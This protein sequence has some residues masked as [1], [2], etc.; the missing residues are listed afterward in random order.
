MNKFDG[1]GDTICIRQE[2]QCL[3]CAGFFPSVSLGLLLYHPKISTVR[4]IK[5]AIICSFFVT[6]IWLL[7][8]KRPYC[9]AKHLN[10]D[11]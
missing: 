4:E 6:Q 5:F 11:V 8:F 2:I 3:P 7:G 1:N 10:H 9:T